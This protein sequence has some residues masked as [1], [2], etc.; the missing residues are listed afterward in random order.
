MNI[1]DSNKVL[2]MG[3]EISTQ[4]TETV[5][6]LLLK[7]KRDSAEAAKTEAQARGK[8]LPATVDLEVTDDEIRAYQEKQLFSLEGEY[9]MKGCS[10]TENTSRSF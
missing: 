2:M 9:V 6:D 3:Q 5:R 4:S 8:R 10:Y 1:L 7:K